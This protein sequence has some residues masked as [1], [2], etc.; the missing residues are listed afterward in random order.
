MLHDPATKTACDADENLP[1]S[2]PSTPCLPGHP[3]CA[4]HGAAGHLFSSIEL[5]RS[6]RGGPRANSGGPRENSGGARSGSG[7]KRRI[8]SPPVATVQPDESPWFC[9]T[10]RG[11]RETIAAEQLRHLGFPV[12]LP[13]LVAVQSRTHIVRGPLFPGYL[14]LG[15]GSLAVHRPFDAPELTGLLRHADGSP[16]HVPAGIVEDLMARADAGGAIQLAEARDTLLAGAIV[17]LRD[18]PL[19]GMDA[20]VLTASRDWVKVLLAV[21]GRQ[22]ETRLR[23]ADVEVA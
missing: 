7:P 20:E 19:A 14:F 9:A 2:A 8:I 4:S 3:E 23:R 18:G 16:Q 22:V 12:H 11:G 15:I 13:I 6:G 17:R 5:R 21:M 1:S 10:T